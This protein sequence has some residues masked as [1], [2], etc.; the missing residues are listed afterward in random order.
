MNG[1]AKT[2]LGVVVAVDETVDAVKGL[3]IHIGNRIGDTALA[4][5]VVVFAHVVIA[6]NAVCKTF[7]LVSISLLIIYCLFDAIWHIFG[8]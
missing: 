6:S 1:C 7:P 5:V 2:V 4:P 3:E 8:G